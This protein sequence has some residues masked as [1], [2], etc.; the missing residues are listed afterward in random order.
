MRKS[1]L[2]R[3]AVPNSLII[4]LVFI[5]AFI[6][7]GILNYR[8]SF[9][10]EQRAVEAY[11]TSSIS[12]V[13][14]KLKDMARVSLI[15]Y[16]DEK[17]QEI[18]SDYSSYTYNQQLESAVYL[19]N[20]MLSMITIR[21]DICGVY[22]FNKR[23][24]I[25][26]YD[27]WGSAAQTDSSPEGSFWCPAGGDAAQEYLS[28]CK[29]TVGGI[30]PF[31]KPMRSSSVYRGDI[32][33]Y[34]AREVK[35]FSPRE[36]IGYILLLSPVQELR[37]TIERYLSDD[38]FYIVSDRQGT[39]VCETSGRHTGQPFADVYPGVGLAEIT[40]SGGLVSCVIDGVS[41]LADSAT[42]DYSGL[43][44]IIGRPSSVIFD[45]TRRLLIL[46]VIISS[47]AVLCSVF[48]TLLATRHTL[49]PIR[50]LSETMEGM[51][52][53]TNVTLPV[54]TE[55]ESGRLTG[56]FNRMMDTINDLISSEYQSTIRLQ[57]AQLRE[58]ETQLLY[59]RSQINPHFLYNTLD[60][61]RMKAAMEGNAQV[62]ELIMMMVDFFR[63][64]IGSKAAVVPLE[65]EVRLAQV[66]F[67]LMKC[68]H[69]GLGDSYDIDHSLDNMLIPSFI[70]QPLVENSI[71]HGLKHVGYKGNILLRAYRDPGQPAHVMIEVADDGVGMDS[72][73]LERIN[74]ALELQEPLPNPNGRDHT[75]IGVMN[76]QDRLRMLYSSDFGLR[77]HHNAE[78][79][80]I[81]RI[82]IDGNV[83][84]DTNFAQKEG[85][86]ETPG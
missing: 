26:K 4:L 76:V 15:C 7:I 70:L 34:M 37:Q 78:R 16:S 67:Q 82:R 57:R 28:G 19:Q 54:T 55:D 20:L 9:E 49:R 63:L 30:P 71:L 33:L 29:L 74:R 6:F 41:C 50:L 65:H 25:Y 21:N 38:S 52:R 81:A 85:F 83:V 36:S 86:Y 1:I 5:V 43:T 59:L 17:T 47:G 35:S 51:G 22:I 64:S 46:L 58:R 84:P 23:A 72:D 12:S 42:S 60:T 53:D 32:Q 80:L 61:I 44:F 13:D 66:Y 27:Y 75:H 3:L 62:A 73:K 48:F 8:L 18:I 2:A 11:L 79:G 31:L 14:N 10:R 40:S 45:S 24:L 69:P 77:F 68:R 39:I 56:A